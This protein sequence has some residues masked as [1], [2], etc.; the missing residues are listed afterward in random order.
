MLVKCI[1]LE[2][3]PSAIFYWEEIHN[4]PNFVGQLVPV[5]RKRFESMTLGSEIEVDDKFGHQL[6]ARYPDN[7]RVS[8]Y[9]A[10]EVQ[11][12]MVNK[13]PREI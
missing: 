12:K 5:K 10:P 13:A 7:L 3:V 2:N 9:G 6:I 1:K 11:N 8:R 4:E